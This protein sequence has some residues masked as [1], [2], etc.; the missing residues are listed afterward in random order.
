MGG[1]QVL[2]GHR[3]LEPAGET[4][5]EPKFRGRSMDDRAPAMWR[6]LPRS[7]EFS[8]VVSTLFDDGARSSSRKE[9]EPVRCQRV[10]G[11]QSQASSAPCASAEMPFPK[12]YG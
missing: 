1:N 3:Q 9:Y 2:P 5:A 6:G 10:N 4:P 11:R 7:V 8:V 12:T